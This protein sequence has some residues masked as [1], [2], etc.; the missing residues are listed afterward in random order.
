MLNFSDLSFSEQKEIVKVSIYKYFYKEFHR[1]ELAELG[2]FE[3][4]ENKLIIKGFNQHATAKKFM[5][6]FG[7]YKKDLI[8]SINKNKAFYVDEDLNIPSIGLNFLGFVDKG[9]DMIEVKPITNCNINCSFCSVNEGISS[10]KKQDFVLDLDYLVKGTKALLDFKGT[11]NISLWINPHGEPLL[12]D[13]LVD[14]CNIIAKDKRIKDIHIVTNATLLNKNIISKL[15]D[16]THLS[17]SI[18][19]FT[20]KKAKELM[21]KNYNINIVLKN[22]KYA[23]EKLNVEITPVWIKGL[24]DYDIKK[25]IEFCKENNLEISIQKFCFNKKGRNP[26][27]ETEWKEFFNNLKLLE[28]ETD[29]KLTK[30]LNKIGKTKPLPEIVHRNEVIDVEI[31]CKGRKNDFIGSI[32]KNNQIRACTVLGYFSN[33]KR[34]KAKVIKS[35]NNIIV[36]KSLN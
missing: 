12:Y 25:I 17:I 33:K 5:R 23:K 6:F 29:Y 14:Y 10:S 21:G 8:Y 9:T 19:A 36:V 35:K 13:M 20:D 26:V 16:K 1:F 28:K 24:N 32:K 15:P 4:K 31:I 22:I 18:S 7:P 34:I 3:I 2:D 27:K 30:Q 11:N